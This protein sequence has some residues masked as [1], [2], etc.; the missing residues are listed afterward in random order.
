MNRPRP[1]LSRTRPRAILPPGQRPSP[2]R[3]GQNL[4]DRATPQSHGWTLL[5]LWGAS[6]VILGLFL[7]THPLVGMLAY[8]P[9]LGIVVIAGGIVTIVAAFRVKGAMA[10]AA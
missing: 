2:T 1:C 9:T 10:A 7:V 3:G 5:L 4:G 6:W 8:V